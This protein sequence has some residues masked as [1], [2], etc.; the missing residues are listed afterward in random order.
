M[1]GDIIILTHFL[2]IKNLT[3]KQVIHE[4]N[5][6]TYDDLKRKVYVLNTNPDKHELYIHIK[7]IKRP[8]KAL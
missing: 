4:R 2:K 1:T 8:R 6:R 5:N 3:I 7:G